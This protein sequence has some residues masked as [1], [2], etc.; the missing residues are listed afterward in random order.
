MAWTLVAILAVAVLILLLRDTGTLTFK[1]AGVTPPSGHPFWSQIFVPDQQT[2]I[3]LADSN[4]VVWQGL[5]KRDIGLSEYLS[6]DYRTT[7]P[8]TATSLQKDALRPARG[9]YT[10]II[11]VD[12]L[13]F[14]S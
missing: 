5:M 3:V 4:L 6:G 9:R 12:M 10:S 2:A 7:I 11:D 14:F 13:Q 8:A 1:K